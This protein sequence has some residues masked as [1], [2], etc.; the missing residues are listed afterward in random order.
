MRVAL[1]T[2]V[3][4]LGCSKKSETKQEPA[5]AGES[6][7]SAT[8]PGAA[9]APQP[10]PTDPPAG[11]QAENKPPVAAEVPAITT[12]CATLLTAD[13]I[14][15][16]CGGSKVEVAE[17]SS[18][19]KMPQTV[20]ALKVTD[21]GKKFPIAQI[22]LMRFA[23]TAGAEGWVKLDKTAD[24]KEVAGLGDAAW[25]RVKE[26]AALKSTD[27]GVGVRKGSAVLKLSMTQSGLVKKVPC[28]IDQLTE[29]AKLVASR[30]P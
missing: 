25:S 16:V 29:L 23:D 28:T 11:E 14:A 18:S 6:P 8:A 27:Y 13:D 4:L 26:S 30:I 21:V 15:K 7:G 24:A 22:Q 5:G 20:C 17:S 10:P 19:I 2:V 1:L 3:L 9:E 12:D